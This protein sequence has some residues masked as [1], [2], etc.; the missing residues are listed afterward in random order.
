LYPDICSLDRYGGL[1]G[2]DSYKREWHKLVMC[3]EGPDEPSKM[4]AFLEP[5]YQSLERLGPPKQQQHH[6][7]QEQPAEHGKPDVYRWIV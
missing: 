5:L 4:D 6:Q 7:Q 3:I 1:S 2:N